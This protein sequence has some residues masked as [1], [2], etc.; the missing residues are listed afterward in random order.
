MFQI[1]AAIVAV[2]VVAVL[3]IA[4]SKPKKFH[5]ERSITV[6]ATPEKLFHLVNDFHKWAL[7]SPYE[8]IDADMKK[9]YSGSEHGKGAIYEWEGKKTGIGRMEIMESSHAKISI[10]LDFMK[11]MEAHNIAD[12]T[13]KKI[14]DE[15]EVTWAM[16]GPASYIVNVMHT[17][18]NMDK[19]L[20]KDFSAG[21][22]AMKKVAEDKK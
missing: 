8:K 18:F 1:I 21:L 16:H 14:N 10:K 9:T 17:V 7:W 19:M 3:G 5:F 11:P 6:K 4:A 20:G 13:F 12:F 15:T 2:P 22:A